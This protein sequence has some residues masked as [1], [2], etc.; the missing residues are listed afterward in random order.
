[1]RSQFQTVRVCQVCGRA[2]PSDQASGWLVSPHRTN[3]NVT[4]VRCP[5]HWSEW[6]LRNCKAGRTKEMREQ[7]ER[8]LAMPVPPIPAALGPFPTRERDDL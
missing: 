1:M 6:A 5:Q 2:T 8:S 4:V 7:M 3:M